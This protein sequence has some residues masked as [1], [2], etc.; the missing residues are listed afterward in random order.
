MTLTVV[1]IALD[2]FVDVNGTL[3][4]AHTPN[5]GPAWTLRAGDGLEIQGN[6]VVCTSVASTNFAV[7]DLSEAD[8]QVTASFHMDV[9]SP[10]NNNF[11]IRFREQAD[12]VGFSLRMQGQTSGPDNALIR[13]D[14]D[15]IEGLVE[16]F[17]SLLIVDQVYTLKVVA[18]GSSVKGYVD[19]VLFYDKIYT[20]RMTETRHGLQ[21]RA[22]GA[23]APEAMP[24]DNFEVLSLE[25]A[26]NCVSNVWTSD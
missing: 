16:D 23:S 19:D 22:L 15:G 10:T 5:I 2:R 21:M 24:M 7:M 8:V 26:Q 17:G 3:L 12:G 9:S 20:Q 4:P 11:G 14:A 25:E 1:Q 6:E 18:I 13:L